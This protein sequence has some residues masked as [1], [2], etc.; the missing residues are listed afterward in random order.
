M[1]FYHFVLLLTRNVQ[2]PVTRFVHRFD[3]DH[4]GVRYV[5]LATLLET[6]LSRCTYR[7]PSRSSSECSSA[8]VLLLSTAVRRRRTF[9]RFCPKSQPTT[10][11]WWSTSLSSW[12]TSSCSL[13]S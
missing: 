11:G 12:E 10:T 5:L 9:K 6:L 1:L 8:L 7:E 13:A 3:L 2:G 4:L